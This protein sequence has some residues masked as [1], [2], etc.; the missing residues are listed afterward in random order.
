[1]M[2]KI[3]FIENLV[4]EEKIQLVDASDDI[5]SSYNQKSK[6]ALKAAKLLFPQELLEEATSM[7]YYAM[8]HKLMSLFFKIG[9]K[10]EN[11]AAAIIL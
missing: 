5:S 2:K 7:A 1:M 9:I 8:F 3:H 6:N 11:H 10:C 4:L